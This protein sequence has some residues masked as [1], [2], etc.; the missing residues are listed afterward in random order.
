MLRRPAGV[1]LAISVVI[2]AALGAGLL[3]VL[4]AP[5][6]TT[7]RLSAATVLGVAAATGGMALAVLAQAF[8]TWDAWAGPVIVTTVALAAVV[9]LLGSGPARRFLAAAASAPPT[10][11]A[12]LAGIAAALAALLVRLAWTAL[13]RIPARTLLTASAGTGRAAGAA[14]TMDPEALAW[15]VEDEHW[16]GRALRSRRWP[17]LPAPMALAW[18]DWRR[19]GRRPGRLAVLLMTAALPALAAQ[20]GG[21]SLEAP[22]A[23]VAQTGGGSLEAPSAVVAQIGGDPRRR[24]P[25][26]PRRWTRAVSPVSCRPWAS[27]SPAG[28]PPRRRGPRARAGTATTRRWRGCSASA[29]AGLSPPGRCCRGCWARPGWS[30]CWA[31]SR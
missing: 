28:S 17:A 7:V 18:Q 22:S 11:G 19:L 4:G 21:G 12:A 30:S 8:R 10:L 15:S 5:D 16:R 26:R 20:T 27:C 1:L 31:G 29:P 13:D 25:C 24:P 9:A 2:G 3:A 6:H 23:V 14:V